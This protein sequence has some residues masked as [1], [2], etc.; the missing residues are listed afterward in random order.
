MASPLAL[1][2]AKAAAAKASEISRNPAASSSAYGG[3][4]SG[5]VSAL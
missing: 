1:E 4:R 3:W 2:M 5:S